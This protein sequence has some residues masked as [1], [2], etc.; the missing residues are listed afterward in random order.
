MATSFGTGPHKRGYGLTAKIQTATRNIPAKVL[1]RAAHCSVR[2]AE[3]AKQGVTTLSLEHFLR[4]AAEIP[5]LR[6]LALDM[7]GADPINPDR[8]RA[9]AMLVSSYMRQS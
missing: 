3:N 6:A 2:T 8:E 5:E 1:A 9:L 7:M 4:A